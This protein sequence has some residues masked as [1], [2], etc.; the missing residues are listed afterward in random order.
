MQTQTRPGLMVGSCAVGRYWRSLGRYHKKVPNSP[1]HDRGCSKTCTLLKS[2]IASD[3]ASLSAAWRL[4]HVGGA[5]A[6]GLEPPPAVAQ[7]C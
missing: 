7:T 5:L 6:V 3:I 4:L 2:P 1:E